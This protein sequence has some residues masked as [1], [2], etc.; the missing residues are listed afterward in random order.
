M[1]DKLGGKI[2]KELA[3]LRPKICSYL[4]GDND[5]NKKKQKVQQIFIKRNLKFEDYK[6]CSQ[7]TQL[8]NQINQLEKK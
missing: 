6:Q 5:E 7:V 1:K 8:Q 2:I 4:T 3:A